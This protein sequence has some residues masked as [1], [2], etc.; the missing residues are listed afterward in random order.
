MSKN[1]FVTVNLEK[2]KEGDTFDWKDSFRTLNY[3]PD[4]IY[5]DLLRETLEGGT[6]YTDT[7][8]NIDLIQIP[9]KTLVFSNNVFPILT[10]KRVSFKNVVSELLWFL[11]GDSNLDFLHEYKNHIW[12]KDSTKFAV[13]NPES[14][15][16]DGGCGRIYGVQWND[17]KRN[18]GKSVNQLNVLIRGLILEPMSRR[19]I[20]TAWNPADMERMALPPCHWAFM[21]IVE[22]FENTYK[23]H[24]KWMQRS[25][26]VFLGIPYNITS[27]A[28]LQR[29][30]CAI[31]GCE[32]GSLIADLSNVHIYK[33]HLSAVNEQLGRELFIETVAPTL[34]IQLPEKLVNAKDLPKEELE[35][36]NFAKQLKKIEVEHFT[37]GNYNP[38]PAIK[39]EMF[40]PL[41]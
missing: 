29:I 11:R 18:K 28:L 33:P 8:R 34:E 23:L 35:K 6:T 25:C 31:T 21:C 20:V 22:P 15:R 38:Q 9:H 2:T 40:A 32:L 19:H 13:R 27:Y 5:T 16:K 4:H 41:K 36:F 39:A 1:K 17:W 10:T 24:L 7:S 3:H 37:L 14:F 26:D 12:D 30:L